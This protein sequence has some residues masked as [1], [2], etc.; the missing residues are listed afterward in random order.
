MSEEILPAG[1]FRDTAG[2]LR[3]VGGRF[4]TKAQL[5]S[6]QEAEKQRRAARARGERTISDVIQSL[7]DLDGFEIRLG[8]QGDLARALKTW[9][10]PD[11]QIEIDPDL[12]LVEVAVALEYGTETTPEF[13]PYRT[14]AE[15]DGPRWLRA[16]RTRIQSYAETGDAAALETGLR[17]VAVAMVQDQKATIVEIDEPPN[18]QETIDRKGSDN[19]MIDT[20]QFLNSQR[21]VLV[22]PGVAPFVA[23]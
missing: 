19:P 16:T 17:Q 3:D 10:G 21:A 12:T 23:G 11:D 4:I 15:A 13:A 14:A 1:A 6:Y 2:R 20:G 9:T 8:I 22:I 18:S 5:A 7:E